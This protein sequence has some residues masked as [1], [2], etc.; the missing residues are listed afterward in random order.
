MSDEA[1]DIWLDFKDLR[2][3]RIVPNWQTLRGWQ[4][5]PRISF[6][7]G[8]LFGPNT[9]RWNKKNEIDP[10]LASRPVERE[11]FET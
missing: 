1:L 8:R 5:D 2:R 11:G 4:D 3:A 6:P 9:R 7:R 10:W